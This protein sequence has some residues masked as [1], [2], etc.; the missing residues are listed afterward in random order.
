MLSVCCA[1]LC[2]RTCILRGSSQQLSSLMW[3]LWGSWSLKL[4]Q[5]I[6]PS[7]LGLKVKVCLFTQLYMCLHLYRQLFPMSQNM[8]LTQ[9]IYIFVGADFTMYM[10]DLTCLCALIAAERNEWVTVLQDCTSGRQRH[11]VMNPGSPLAPDYQ[12]YLELKG[13]RSKLYTVVAS[14]K[15]F[16]YKNIDVRTLGAAVCTDLYLR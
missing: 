16:L 15:V 3:P 9:F 14:D 12:G 1:I 2:C 10:S 5:T 7:S 8:Q 4:L 11:T 13:L 6:E